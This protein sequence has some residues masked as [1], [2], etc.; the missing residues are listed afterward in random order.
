MASPVYTAFTTR[1][2]G[3]GDGKKTYWTQ[4]G[5][6]FAHKSGK[7]YDILLDALPVNGKIVLLEPKERDAA[8][9]P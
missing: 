2:Y 5:S 1:E 7:G 4:I 3:E 8:K 9:Q 6:V